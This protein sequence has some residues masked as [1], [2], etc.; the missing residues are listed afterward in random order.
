MPPAPTRVGPTPLC[1][2]CS[3]AL[4]A[5]SCNL[6]VPCGNC[7]APCTSGSAHDG[8]K[9]D[10][11][12][13]AKSDQALNNVCLHDLSLCVSG[14]TFYDVSQIQ[15]LNISSAECDK[16]RAKAWRRNSRTNEPQCNGC[17]SSKH[18]YPVTMIERAAE[19]KLMVPYRTPVLPHSAPPKPASASSYATAVWAASNQ[20]AQQSQKQ[21]PL[22]SGHPPPQRPT[23]QYLPVAQQPAYHPS[24]RPRRPRPSKVKTFMPRNYYRDEPS[25]NGPPPPKR[26]VLPLITATSATPSAPPIPYQT[27]ALLLADLTRLLTTPHAGRAFDFRGSFAVVGTMPGGP[28]ARVVD[29]GWEIIE[30]TVLTFNVNTLKIQ[31]STHE[32]V[33]T[34]QTSAIWMSAPPP[35][36]AAESRSKSAKA[37]KMSEAS[38][39]SNPETMKASETVPNDEASVTSNLKQATPCARCEHLLTISVSRDVGK[40]V[41]GE[42]ISVA[43]RHFPG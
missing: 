42:R 29:V 5:P 31:S 16:C 9:R 25:P 15:L 24:K 36:K 21:T 35:P 7:G 6:P 26:V 28:A 11:R 4:M 27:L 34:T 8:L 38:K 2:P 17:G 19:L 3:F 14:P 41:S 43:L 20:L 32:A 40:Y 12:G 39:S 37:T 1:M 18:Y 10:A 33:T 22:P 23:A 30:K 13:E